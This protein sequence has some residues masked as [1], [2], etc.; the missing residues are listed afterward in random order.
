L[1]ADGRRD[2]VVVGLGRLDVVVYALDA[3]LAERL[4]ARLAQ[5]PDR[6]AALEV[7]VLGDEARAVEHPL[8]VALRQP[9]A[10]RDHAEAVRP[11]RLGRARVLEDLL[12][13]HHRVHRRLR[14][15]EARLRAEAAVLRAAAR[16][17]VDERAQVRRVAEALLPG[18]PRALDER[19]DL[20]VVGDLA[21][22]E[23][24]LAGD[25]RRHGRKPRRRTGRLTARSM[26][27]H[28]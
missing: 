11:R 10:L 19:L 9:L 23:G 4:R 22:G 5:M 27:P 3:R 28:E 21:E 15:G 17:R 13:L 16:L 18:L 7:R 20:G 26:T 2:L 14:V 1:V 25:E 12:G 8:E 6:R 24:L